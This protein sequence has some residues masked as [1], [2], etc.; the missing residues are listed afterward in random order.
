MFFLINESIFRRYTLSSFAFIIFV[1]SNKYFI[2]QLT[3]QQKQSHY[4]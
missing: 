3:N 4:T 1:Y 2:T